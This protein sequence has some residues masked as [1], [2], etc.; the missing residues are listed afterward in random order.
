MQPKKTTRLFKGWVPEMMSLWKKS[1]MN[2]VFSLRERRSI[3]FLIS[4][5]FFWSKFETNRPCGGNL[6]L[7][8]HPLLDFQGHWMTSPAFWVLALLAAHIAQVDH[9]ASWRCKEK[10][11]TW[12]GR[13]FFGKYCWW[14][15]SCTTKD[16][17]DP[18]IYGVLYIP[19]GAGFC[20]STV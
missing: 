7:G 13:M 17:D 9:F 10:V 3:L 19:G 6:L 11:F 14:T 4:S 5:I 16:D 12:I 15:K 2:M 8:D 1:S 18:I 20:P